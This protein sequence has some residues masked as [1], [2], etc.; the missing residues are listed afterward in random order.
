MVN[1]RNSLST[2]R[3]RQRYLLALHT[4]VFPRC[5]V[6]H[7]KVDYASKRV[8]FHYVIWVRLPS[9]NL[10]YDSLAG[11]A[12]AIFSD[13]G[14]SGQSQENKHTNLSSVE[15]ERLPTQISHLIAEAGCSLSD[16]MC[17]MGQGI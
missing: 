5:R 4:D 16:P 1:S 17:R 9:V 7:L 13:D 10:P 15:L 3:C 6:A 14:R 12:S 11:G 2:L 8:A